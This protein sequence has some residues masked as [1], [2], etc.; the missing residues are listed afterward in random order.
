M[1]P[2]IESIWADIKFAFR[3]LRKSP[4]FTITVILTLALGIGANTAIFSVVDALM[5]RPLPYSE[6]ARLGALVTH[7]VGPHGVEDDDS[8]NG[9][10]YMMVRDQVP[11]VTAAAEGMDFGVD[12][13]AAQS[14]QYVQQ[15]R[16]SSKYFDVLGTPLLMGRSFTKEEDSPH[17][18]NVAIISNPLWRNTFHSDGISWVRRFC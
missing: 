2:L 15:L 6:P 10:T 13:Q 9:E 7:W 1:W 4:G 5:L 17:G 11:A 14:V 18:P 16:V 12:L 8:A 3:Q